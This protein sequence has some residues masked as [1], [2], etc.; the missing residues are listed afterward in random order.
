MATTSSLYYDPT[1]PWGFLTL[2]KLRAAVGRKG[3][4]QSVGS[5]R[6]WLEEHDAYTL[7]RPV[8]KHLARNPYTVTNVMDV[9]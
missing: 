6:A 3:R 9:W 2:P 7:H 1:R 8:R 4:P 5:I